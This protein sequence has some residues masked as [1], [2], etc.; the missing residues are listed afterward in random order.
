MTPNTPATPPAGRPAG[1][2]GLDGWK[3]I[4]QDDPVNMMSY[5][6]YVL[7]SQLEMPL[8]RAYDTML[9]IHENGHAVVAQ[10]TREELEIALDRL[11]SYGLLAQIRRVTACN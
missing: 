4:V 3:L 2:I 10:G 11:H 6:V 9:K 8:S 7:R 5:V 1:K